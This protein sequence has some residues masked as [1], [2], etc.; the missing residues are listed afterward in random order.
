[1]KFKVNVKSKE[2]IQYWSGLLVL[3]MLAVTLL[4]F[5]QS[6]LAA[7]DTGYR[8]FSYSGTSAPTGQRPQS[9]LWVNDG[10]WWGA[11]YNKS[12]RQFEIYRFN[13]ATDTWTA[14]GTLIDSRAKSSADA[15]WDGSRLYIMSA[16]P[17][18]SGGDNSI[19]LM[20]YSY[21]SASKTYSVDSG[22]PVTIISRNV[23]LVVME[24][25]TLGKLWLTYTYDNPSSG[26]SVYVSHTTTNDLTW[27]TPYVIPLSGANNLNS[28]DISAI[29]SFNGN[30]GVMWSNQDTNSM[31][32]G[33]HS[34]G[35]SDSSWT[36]NPALQ[37]PKYVDDHINLKSLTADSSGQVY[38]VVKT[39]LND[40][41]PPNSSEPL[42]LLLRLDNSG[43]WTR[44]TVWRV[45]D[46]FTR[47]IVLLDTQNR[48]IYTFG[49]QEYPNQTSGAIY[50]KQI[51]LDDPGA[52]FTTGL[53]TP[54]M[55]FSTDTHIN[56]ASSTK[57]NL[58]SSTG[59]LVIA[60]DDTSHYYFHNKLTLGSSQP[61]A[62]NTA[63]ST[64]TNTPT[65][66]ATWTPTNPPTNT[67]TNTPTEIL[68]TD[69][70]TNTPTN[71]PTDT[72]ID[73][74]TNTPTDTPTAVETA[75]DTP[76]TTPTD[77]STSTPTEM[78]PTNTP[79]TTP[80]NTPIDTP[81]NTPTDTPT[82]TSTNI[83]TDPPTNTP[84]HT[85]T[86]M[87]ID[88]PTSIPTTT[89]TPPPTATISPILFSDG[90]ESGNFNAWSLVK[91]GG[92]GVAMV[93][94]TT[95]KTGS[96]AAQLSETANT[97]SLAYIRASLS[98]SQTNL[99]VS[100]DIMITQEGVSGANVPIL[101][102]FDSSGTRLISLYRQNL[103]GNRIWINHSG[104]SI[105][106]TGLLSLNA[107]THFDMHVITAGT[108][109]STIE[110]YQNGTLIYQTTTA[111]LGTSGVLSTQVGNETAKQT[112]TLFADNVQVSR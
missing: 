41:N 51:P 24:K 13:W 21:N 62:T 52:Q 80:T 43:S 106:T 42:I 4:P 105:S 71:T 72:P 103:S 90:F 56:N 97:G 73:T 99:T 23:E 87:P 77:T 58:N 88:T 60:G 9:K 25:D 57:Q 11:L 98:A 75:A 101:R 84:T 108:N 85:P 68:P 82:A 15:L 55:V 12:S 14:T 95:V 32:F 17:P 81:T 38:A 104:T 86:S 63:T 47:P 20:R 5:G 26:R 69:T 39:S 92:D 112:F 83:P 76:T 54:F 8:D 35:A 65:R 30:I 45:S 91:T 7:T 40:V 66:T 27:I 18:G 107:W 53:G 89:Y 70:P 37:G 19:R 28:D 96:F 10:F 36:A 79:T 34:D 111:S 64:S 102:L 50:Y 22:F 16:V 6:A 3:A 46:N 100:L 93:Q 67:P 44:R 94:S 31:Y 2:I 61:T 1:M 74:P 109:T 59:L 48:N 49:T 33:V 29:V 110:A 78:L